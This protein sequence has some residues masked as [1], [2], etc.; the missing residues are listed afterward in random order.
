MGR[1][2]FDMFWWVYIVAMKSHCHPLLFRHWILIQTYPLKARLRLPTPHAES[3]ITATKI[4]TS[5]K[6]IGS[7]VTNRSHHDKSTKPLKNIK[8]F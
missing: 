5:L 2:L 4:T 6:Y 7:Y 8:T 1:I 3:E